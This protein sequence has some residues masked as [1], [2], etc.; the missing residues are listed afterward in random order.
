MKIRIFLFL[1]YSI[2]LIRPYASYAEPFSLIPSTIDFSGSF[3]CGFGL[4]EGVSSAKEALLETG[5]IYSKVIAAEHGHIDICGTWPIAE[6]WGIALDLAVSP[7][8]FAVAGYD[9]E[10]VVS[11]GRMYSCLSF[12]IAVLI[13]FS[14]NLD[15]GRMFFRAGPVIGINPL[16]G[17]VFLRSEGVISEYTVPAEQVFDASLGGMVSTGFSFPAGPGYITAGLKVTY[18][19]ASFQNF[20]YI[21]SGPVHIVTPAVSLGYTFRIR[22]NG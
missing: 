4:G 6:G 12:N 17:Q 13:F 8:A 5:S 21:E 10:G 16:D 15:N 1:A 3:G 11:E 18:H 2:L 7:T 9:G 20:F 19:Y 22:G 14:L